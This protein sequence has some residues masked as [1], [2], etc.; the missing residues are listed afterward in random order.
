MK[1]YRKKW[2]WLVVVI[3]LIAVGLFA[4]FGQKKG[5]SYVTATAVLGDLKQTV[6]VTGSVTSA[7]EVNLNFN[8]PGKIA[9][10]SV[11]TGDS[12]KA[13]QLLAALVSTDVGS[14]ISDARA[15]VDI[16]KSQ[17]DQLIAG[18]STQDIEVTRQELAAAQIAYQQAQDD[19]TAL[20]QTRD[21]NMKNLITTA[22]NTSNNKLATA[23]YALDV[24]NDAV[25]DNEAITYLVVTDN[26]LLVATRSGYTAAKNNYIEAAAAVARAEQSQNYDDTALAGEKVGTDLEQVLANINNSYTLMSGA[27]PNNSVYTSAVIS[28]FKTSLSTQATAVSTAITTMQTDLANLKNYNL[29]Y[30]TQIKDAQNNIEAKQASLNLVQAKLDLKTAKPRDFEIS[31]AQAT[32]RRAQAALDRYLSEYNKTVITAP[33]DGVVTDVNYKMGEQTMAAQP[34]ITMIGL[35]DKEIEVD[36]PESDIAKVKIGQAVEITLDAFSSDQKFQGQVMFIDPAS[37]NINNVI[38]YKVKVNFTENNELIKAGMTANLVINTDSRQGVL[39]V[40]SRAVIYRENV[41]YVQLLENGQLVEKP[42]ETGL[43]GDDGN[44]EVLSGIKAGDTVVTYI[45]TTK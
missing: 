28:A 11:K 18:A 16:A 7:A 21:L 44:V 36:V 38:Y 8:L 33:F 15:A 42:V 34:V 23:Q 30:S 17:Y 27:L 45:N 39:T 26:S 9:K 13:N 3:V 6:E 22:L 14:Q 37:T 20:E 43:R 5:P 32:I 29:S 31:S 40:P 4:K 2:F 12:V 41:K 1:F 10:I 24:V 35:A 25:I 19:L